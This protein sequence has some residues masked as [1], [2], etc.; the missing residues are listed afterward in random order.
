MYIPERQRGPA[1]LPGKKMPAHRRRLVI[2][3]V[4]IFIIVLSFF[5]GRYSRNKPYVHQDAAGSQ[6]GQPAD[7]SG[8]EG[9]PPDSLPH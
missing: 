8:K 9:I 6:M 5:A 7:P 4:V 2:L 1:G 3:M